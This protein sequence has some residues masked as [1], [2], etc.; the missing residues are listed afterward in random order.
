MDIVLKLFF[1]FVV[2]FSLFVV[3]L[4]FP[5]SSCRALAPTSGGGD[6]V[7]GGIGEWCDELFERRIYYR[8]TVPNVRADGVLVC[9]SVFVGRCARLKR[10]SG[11][12][13]RRL[14][15]RRWP[16][17]CRADYWLLRAWRVCAR[18]PQ[19]R[20]HWT[21]PSSLAPSDEDFTGL[22]AADPGGGGGQM[23]RVR[24]RTE[25]GYLRVRGGVERVENWKRVSRSNGT[26]VFFVSCL[27]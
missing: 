14:V 6:G 15:R 20:R 23:R 5:F 26:I 16:C 24:I 10:F 1:L 2:F 9:V 13:V 12:G 27:D 22:P 17:Y 25:T 4:V 8:D 7:R 21:A 19:R 18:R 3:F 11:D